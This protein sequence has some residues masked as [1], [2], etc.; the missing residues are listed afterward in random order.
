MARGRPRKPASQLA[1]GFILC[2][3]LPPSTGMGLH[4]GKKIYRSGRDWQAERVILMDDRIEWRLFWRGIHVHQR[5]GDLEPTEMR[6][7]LIT[8]INQLHEE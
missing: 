8:E 7:W 2:R 5:L 1:D 4:Q 3:E 6:E